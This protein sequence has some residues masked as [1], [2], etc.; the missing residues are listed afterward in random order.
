MYALSSSDSGD[1]S[2]SRLPAALLPEPSRRGASARHV[3]DT[4]VADGRDGDLLFCFYRTVAT[5]K[6]VVDP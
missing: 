6:G 3:A 5:R 2:D 1:M 4:F